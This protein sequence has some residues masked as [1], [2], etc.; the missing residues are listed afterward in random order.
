MNEMEK[1]VKLRI[2]MPTHMI[3]EWYINAGDMR[4]RLPRK[5]KKRIKRDFIRFLEIS[6][7]GNAM[8]FLEERRFAEGDDFFTE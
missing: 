6:V 1:F 8:S 5:T 7:F 4:T 2:D 3:R